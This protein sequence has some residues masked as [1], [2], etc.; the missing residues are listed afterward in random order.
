MTGGSLELAFRKYFICFL[1]KVLGK[2]NPLFS[3]QL[4]NNRRIISRQK[5]SEKVGTNKLPGGEFFS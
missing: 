3:N 1:G 4:Y 5:K 2:P